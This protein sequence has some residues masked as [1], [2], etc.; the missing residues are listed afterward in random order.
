MSREIPLYT[1]AGVPDAEV[2]IHRFETAD[3]L[4][5][6]LTRFKKE[7]SADPVMIIHGL[8]T[9]SDMFIMP[10][11][12]N[13]VTYL[14]AQGFGDVFCLDYR[15]SN[16]FPY[17]LTPHRFTMDDIAAFD[18][19]PAVEKIRALTGSSRLHVIA[20]C[21]GSISFLMSLFGKAVEG[22]TSVV[23]NSAGLTPRVPR[24]SELKLWTAP[25]LLERVLQQPYVS[26]SFR[27]FP[28]GMIGNLVARAVD[29]LHPECDESACHMLSLMWGTGFPAL[30]SHGNL[31]PVTHRRSGDLY[32]PTGLHYYRHVRKMVSAGHAVKYDPKNEQ[33]R[34]LPDD[35]RAFVPEVKTPVMLMTGAD[36]QVFANSNIVC[37]ELLQKL[38]PGR[39]KLAVIPGYGH[40]DIFMGKRVASEVFPPIADFLKQHRQPRGVSSA[41]PSALKVVS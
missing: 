20:H 15:M 11:H 33:L 3:G 24:W 26:P 6:T 21:L 10:E 22:I 5:L 2:S 30:Y 8:T 25:F 17:N 12:T 32:G 7:S 14:H 34:A 28:D 18:Y 4:G 31:D 40:Q 23:A 38:A 9:S 1:L 29:L 39:H 37:A 13:L 41:L 27:E 35:Y 36:N 19:P 16:H